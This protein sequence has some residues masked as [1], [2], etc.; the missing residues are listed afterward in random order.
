MIIIKKSIE[1]Q[2]F[3]ESDTWLFPTKVSNKKN[4]TLRTLT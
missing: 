1:E 3:F 4:F 2:Q